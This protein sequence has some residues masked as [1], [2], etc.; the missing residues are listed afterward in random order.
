MPLRIGIN[1]ASVYIGDI[2]DKHRLDFTVIGDGVNFAQR[3]ESACSPYAINLSEQTLEDSSR[4]SRDYPGVKP[5]S[6]RIKHQ[7]ELI[8]VFELNPF[9]DNPKQLQKAI[10][11]YRE[12]RNLIRKYTRRTISDSSLISIATPHGEATLIDFSK[13]GLSIR[14][15]LYLAG[16]VELPI[17]LAG[18]V[19][20]NN[21]IRRIGA[22]DVV[23]EIRWS[24]PSGDSFVHG[25]QLKGLSEPQ[26]E[27]LYRA[28]R[29]LFAGKS[30]I[31]AA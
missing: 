31:A 15:P 13:N 18:D 11:L 8:E 10:E 7:D 20:F 16:G 27:S 5:L 1:T 29:R 3:L 25:L 22:E 21:V 30:D 2:G 4:F 9:V 14:L 19:K 17:T 28:F 23:G 6:I 24:K 12:S 26:Q